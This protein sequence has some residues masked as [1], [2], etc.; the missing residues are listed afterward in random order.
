MSIRELE[1]Q[2]AADARVFFCNKKLRLKD[3]C[4]WSTGEVKPREDE[5]AAQLPTGIWVAILK[6]NDKRPAPPIGEAGK[7]E[8]ND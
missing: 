7:G 1:S 6:I 3:I 2:I 8:A 5:V 4:E